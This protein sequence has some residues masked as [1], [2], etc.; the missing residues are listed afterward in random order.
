MP[1]TLLII[2]DVHGC[3]YTFRSLLKQY[4]QPETMRLIQLGDLTDRGK[5]VPETIAFARE[6]EEKHPNEVTFLK[7]NHEAMVLEYWNAMRETIPP[8]AKL[9][10]RKNSTMSQYYAVPEFLERLVEDMKWLKKRPLFWENDHVFVSH[11]GIAERWNTIKEALVPDHED[12]ILWT[13]SRLKNIG[14]LQVIGHTPLETGEPEFREAE[15]CWNIDTAAV[16]GVNL[17]ALHLALDGTVLETFT[18]PSRHVD[19]H[20]S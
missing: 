20:F 15:N 10:S 19:Y 3:F 7:G 16:F 6:L 5:F 18:V 12:N 17:T 8:I 9:Y 1:E 4:W 13:R 11:A 2:G 14:K